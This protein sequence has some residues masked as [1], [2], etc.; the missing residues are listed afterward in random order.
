MCH[1]TDS[2]PIVII[3]FITQLLQLLILLFCSVTSTACLQD[4]FHTFQYMRWCSASGPYGYRLQVWTHSTANVNMLSDLHYTYS[5][6]ISQPASSQLLGNGLH[7]RDA[8]QVFISQHPAHLCI[9][10]DHLHN[11][12]TLHNV[13]AVTKW[14]LVTLCQQP[15]DMNHK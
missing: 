1:K 13:T 11:I 4:S 8:V 15:A 10:Q 5:S 14:L 2:S 12:M 9:L 6:H 7:V 3:S